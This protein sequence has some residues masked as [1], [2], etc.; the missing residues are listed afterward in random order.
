MGETIFAVATGAGRSAIAVIRVSGP[1]AGSTLL[2]LTQRPLP[3]PRLATVRTLWDPETGETLDRG[4]VLWFPAPAS[5]T[6][7]DVVELHVHGGRAVLSSVCTTLGRL[8][9]LRPAEPGE[10]SRRA[11]DSGKL[12]LTEIEG[13]ADLIDAETRYQHR[14]A[15]RQMSGALS[16]L[17][18]GWRGRLVAVLAHLEADLDFPDEDLPVGLSSA[19]SEA[20]TTLIGEI[21][22]HLN[23]NRR[24]ERLRAGLTIALVGPPNVG[25]STL[26]NHLAGREVAIVSER[27]GTTRDVIEVHL[28]LNGLP[29]IVADTAG[30]RETDDAIEGEGVRRAQAR[31]TSADITVMVLDADHW[32]PPPDL[33]ALMTADT[34]VVINKIDQGLP[35]RASMAGIKALRISALTEDGLPEFLMALTDMAQARLGSGDAPVLTRE[36]YRTAL[37]TCRTHLH[38]A[39]TATVPELLAEDVRL[40][41]RA[42]GRITGRVDVDDL[43][44]VIFRDFCIGK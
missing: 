10:F 28:D 26:L 21:D 3:I 37:E 44:D 25:K 24:G 22:A 13:L 36:R 2:T 27:A 1:R 39:S 23:D 20:V 14:L 30:L 29:V 40:A 18:D 5:A 42:L 31:A 4:L 16:R 17:Y 33:A 19:A 8:A 6:G 38:A 35:A 34:L 41:V 32:P 7:E 15:L 9:A 43:L 11:F 12:D